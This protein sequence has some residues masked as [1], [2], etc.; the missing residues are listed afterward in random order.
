MKINLTF[1]PNKSEV[2]HL[3]VIGGV[4][5]KFWILWKLGHLTNQYFNGGV[6]CLADEICIQEANGKRA[7]STPEEFSTLVLNAFTW[8]NMTKTDLDKF[9]FQYWDY[10]S[11]NIRRRVCYVCGTES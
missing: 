3:F 1:N 8:R 7:Y 10:F 2:R 6:L 4:A 11:P 9:I 5:L